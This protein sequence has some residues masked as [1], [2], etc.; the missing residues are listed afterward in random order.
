MSEI[1]GIYM[2]TKL[3]SNYLNVLKYKLNVCSLPNY[4]RQTV[5]VKSFGNRL[6]SLY[7]I[8]SILK[9]HHALYILIKHYNL[10]RL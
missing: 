4:Y 9:H 7:W 5:L 2:K 6:L 10:M 1:L 8:F 3:T